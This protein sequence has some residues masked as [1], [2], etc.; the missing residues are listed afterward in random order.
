MIEMILLCCKLI[1]YRIS[2]NGIGHLGDL[3]AIE[4]GNRAHG[5]FYINHAP[6]LNA[7]I[8]LIGLICLP[9]DISLK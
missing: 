8:A 9:G 4:D 7:D 3:T 6:I 1:S 2:Q 5:A